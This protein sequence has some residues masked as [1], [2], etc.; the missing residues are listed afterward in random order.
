MFA[1]KFVAVNERRAIPRSRTLFRHDERTAAELEAQ[2]G[3]IRMNRAAIASRPVRA[4]PAGRSAGLAGE[5]AAHCGA[6]AA[7]RQRRHDRAP[8]RRA[9]RR[10][11]AA[12]RLRG[13]PAGRERNGGI[14]RGRAFRCRRLH[15]RH[16]RHSVARDRARDQHK[17]G[18]RSVAGFHPHRLC[19]R[20]TDRRDGARVARREL[21]RRASGARASG[22]EAPPDMSRRAWDRSVTWS[23]NIWRARKTSRSSTCRTRAGCRR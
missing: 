4:Q 11:V 22:A 20:L 18:I 1:T 9:T 5:A 14:G 12:E 15:L 3:D 21:F 19:G 10:D 16:F 13:E 23:A 6:L 8:A 17:C 2:G 7:R